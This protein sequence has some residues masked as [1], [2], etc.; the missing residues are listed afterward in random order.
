M[1][2]EQ[3]MG[4]A[5]EVILL[6]PDDKTG[7]HLAASMLPPAGALD[8]NTLKDSLARGWNPLLPPLIAVRRKGKIMMVDGRSRR[9]AA[10][11]LGI[12]VPCA[13]CDVEDDVLFQFAWDANVARRTLKPMQKAAAFI[14]LRQRQD[15]KF[16]QADVM[17]V[18]VVSK[19]VASTLKNALQ[20]PHIAA[21]I[22]KHLQS[23]DEKGIA[24]ILYPERY[25]PE[26]KIKAILKRS[27]SDQSTKNCDVKLRQK[28]FEAFEIACGRA[29]RTE[30]GGFHR[31]LIRDIGKAAISGAAS[32]T[33]KF[34]H[35][36]TNGD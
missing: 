7:V 13:I 12:E 21:K 33:L 6:G 2:I 27:Q 18:A 28:E 34:T 8:Y 35:P 26:A 30:L 10:R 29:N 31:Q 17:K 11:D 15:A 16:T 23:G 22:D 3:D 5:R 19:A 32:F 20:N 25:D 4:M 24:R 14:R 9:D 1:T 36:V